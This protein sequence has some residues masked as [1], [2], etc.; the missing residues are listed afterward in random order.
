MNL[1]RYARAA[2]RA[3]WRAANFRA[4]RRLRIEPSKVILSN[5]NGIGYGC[6]PKYIAEEILRRRLPWDLVWVTKTGADLSGLP[7]TIRTVP[8]GSM[9]FLTEVRS[10]RTWIANVSV[11]RWRVQ[12]HPK[13]FYLQTGHGSFGIKRVGLGAN[14]AS[15]KRARRIQREAA[16]LD[17]FLSHSRFETGVYQESFSYGHKVLELGHARN[18]ILFDEHPELVAKVRAYFG[19]PA[20]SHIMLHVP[21]FRSSESIEAY[22]LDYLRALGALEARFGGSWVALARFHP[23]TQG[24]A[25]SI[26]A[27]HSSRVI[28]ATRYDDIQELLLAADVAITDYSSC[29]FDFML[30]RRPGFFYAPDVDHYH[31][32]H[33]LYFPLESTPFPACRSNDEL[34]EAIAVWDQDRYEDRVTEFLAARGSVEDGKAAARA[35]DLLEDLMAS[36]M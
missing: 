8:I 4:G 10:A 24:L 25:D 1:R 7:P 14:N 33:G 27:G 18:D 23:R 31:E 19:I 17:Y 34:V 11:E 16:D 35:V 22:D 28:D 9:K 20:D 15:I 30:R 5:F 13:Q 26:L 21:S 29:I 36:P 32:S 3:A 6:N 2:R 12:K